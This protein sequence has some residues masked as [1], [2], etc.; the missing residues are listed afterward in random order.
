[1]IVTDSMI[2]VNSVL[3]GTSTAFT[4]EIT[5]EGGSLDGREVVNTY[6]PI[7]KS[8]ERYIFFLNRARASST[9]RGEKSFTYSIAGGPAGLAKITGNQIQFGPK[10]EERISRLNSE[11]LSDISM[12]IVDRV[13]GKMPA[14]LTPSDLPVPR[15]AAE[16]V[17]NLQAEGNVKKGNQ[18]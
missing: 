3:K 14:G 16:K 1:M 9:A 6:S 5:Q 18:E 4:I 2:S 12:R 8:G 17:R 13:F 7:V 11:S 15:A 10:V